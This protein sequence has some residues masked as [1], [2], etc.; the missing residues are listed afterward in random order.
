MLQQQTYTEL[1]LAEIARRHVSISHL[2]R[3]KLTSSD[4]TTPR[5]PLSLVPTRNLTTTMT[6]GSS[7]FQS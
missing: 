2:L 1:D 6:L 4:L 7:P 5:I 3:S